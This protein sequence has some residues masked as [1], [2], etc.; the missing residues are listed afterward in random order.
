M[1]FAT[2]VAVSVA[3]GATIQVLIIRNAM[4]YEREVSSIL[5]DIHRETNERDEVDRL[6][7]KCNN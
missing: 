5:R 3:I 7:R 1:I 4:K 6:R 2:I